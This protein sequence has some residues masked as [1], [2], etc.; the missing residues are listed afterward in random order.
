MTDFKERISSEV[1]MINTT[2]EALARL[3]RR[4][5][6][7]QLRN[8]L[9]A[10]GIGVVLTAA[11]VTGLWSVE[12]PGGSSIRLESP[13]PGRSPA[14]IESPSRGEPEQLRRV[15]SLR[16]G[17]FGAWALTCD[18]RCSGDRRNSMGSVVRVDM[19]SGRALDS[20]TLRNASDIAVGE[21]AVWVRSFWDSTVSRI[22]PATNEVVATINLKLPF[23]VCESCPGGSDF[24]PYDMAVGEGALWV[25]TARGALA[26]I[27]PATNRVAATIRL[28]GNSTGEIAVGEGAVWITEGVLGLYRLDPATNDITSRIAIDDPPERRLSVEG[29]AVGGGSVWAQGGWTQETTQS[30]GAMDYVEMG[31]NALVQIDPET[32]EAVRVSEIDGFQS[33]MVFDRSSLWLLKGRIVDE[34]DPAT[35]RMVRSVKA[36]GGRFLT[37]ADGIGWVLRPNGT[38]TKVDLSS[39]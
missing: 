38:L 3:L 8:R 14:E 39:Q 10:G 20:V 15:D 9:A 32:N 12:R 27:D 25:V 23:A 16:L 7:R 33:E 17:D 21:G 11:L 6:R 19:A 22:D 31:G 28:P 30:P 37:I 35:G 4:V 26:R 2:D 29:V 18:R 13:R 5:R 34:I 1:K 24:H 36:K